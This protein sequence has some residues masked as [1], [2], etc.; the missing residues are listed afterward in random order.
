MTGS[1]IL[2]PAA[3]ICCIIRAGPAKL[4]DLN[5]YYP[6]DARAL[7]GVSRQR[8]RPSSEP[9]VHESRPECLCVD[10]GEKYRDWVV[11]YVGA[12]KQRTEACGGNIPTNVGLDGKP[13]GEYNGQWWKGTYGWNFTIFDGEFEETAHR[14]YFTAGAWPG[15]GNALMLT[16]DQS[17]YGRTSAADGQHLRAEESGE[18]QDSAASDVWRSQGYKGDGVAEL[19]SLHGQSVSGPFDGDLLLVDGRRI[20]SEFR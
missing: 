16:G 10:A 7:Q 17:L 14:N 18:R 20:W 9:C 12:W 1:A 5:A 15:F 2:F 4:L 19:V 3:S 11:E 8:R 6:E 13:G